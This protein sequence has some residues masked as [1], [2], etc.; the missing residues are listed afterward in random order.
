MNDNT[1]F[2]LGES[3]GVSFDDQL[4]NT[5]ADI[6]NLKDCHIQWNLVI[7]FAITRFP[8]YRGS[9]LCKENRSLYRK[10]LCIEVRLINVSLYITHY[11]GIIA[12]LPTDK[13]EPGPSPPGLCAFT[14]K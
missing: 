7:T 6:F 1:T 10:V 12:P 5:D 8:L 3:S 13:L 4:P 11:S 9:F 14:E 2:L